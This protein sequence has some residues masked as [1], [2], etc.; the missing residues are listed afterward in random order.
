MNEVCED[1]LLQFFSTAS[2]S[3]GTITNYLLD[4]DDNNAS[5]LGVNPSYQYLDPGVYS[6]ELTV[7]SDQSCSASLIQPIT[8]HERPVPAIDADDVCSL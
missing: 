1:D 2:I 3:A 8:I 4:F 6:V 7:T 5:S